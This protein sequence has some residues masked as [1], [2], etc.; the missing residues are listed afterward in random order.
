MKVK[1]EEGLLQVSMHT[2]KW[3]L[4]TDKGLEDRKGIGFLFITTNLSRH[5]HEQGHTVELF[6]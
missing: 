5:A 2:S 1:G 4:L 6:W 3:L